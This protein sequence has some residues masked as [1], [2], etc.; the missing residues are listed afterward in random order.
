[1]SEKWTIANIP[2]L[3][4]KVMIV[5]G[6]N[7]GIGFEEI[8]EFSRKGAQTV[9]A[10]RNLAKAKK[11]K[12]KILQSIPEAKIDIMEIDLANLVSIHHFSSIFKQKYQKLDVLVNNAGIMM[13]P[14]RT[15]A[16]GFES[17]IGTNHLGHFA[18]TGLLLD[19]LK[20]TKGSR[21]V[22]VSSM[23]HRSG[24][25]DFDNF[26]YEDGAS[27]TKTG[28]Y[29]RSK[30][31]NLLFTYELNRRLN[32][33][34]APTISVASHP[35]IS[36]TSLA[37][38]MYGIFKFLLKPISGIFLQ[39]PAKGA[40]A[41]IR[42]A[43]DSNVKGGEYFGPKGRKNEFRGSPVKVESSKA[44]HNQDDARRLWELSEKLT[45]ITYHF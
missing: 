18:L 32:K 35:G 20:Q 36:N 17:Q 34:G 6:G 19:I 16:D 14:Y 33:S 39:S 37:D 23:G 38:H 9:M 31:A 26:L 13:V 44:S 43:V 7:S 12:E 24:V 21:I 10:S 1:M 22:N 4:G 41:T 29:G 42:A 3:T 8:K 45:K 25:M 40:L 15:T 30:L 28:A 11:A 27:Y 2:D 5:T